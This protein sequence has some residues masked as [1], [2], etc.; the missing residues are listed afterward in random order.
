MSRTLPTSEHFRLQQIAEG[1]YAAIDI[2]RGAAFS[3]A[4]II[5]LGDLTLIF[6]TLMTPQAARD[7][8]AAAEHLTGRPTD[9]CVNSHRHADH[10]SGSQVFA[11]HATIISTD[12]T[13]E[14][15]TM[16]VAPALTQ[17]EESAVAVTE[18]MEANKERLATEKDERW[19][20][21]LPIRI[22]YCQHILESLPTLGLCFP[23]L[24]FDTKLVFHGSARTA[25]LLARSGHMSSDAI[26]VLPTE[27]IAFMGDLAF[28]Q[29]HLSMATSDPVAWTAVLEELE[30]PDI[31]TFVPG[32]GPVGSR[33][34]VAVLKQYIAA[35]RELTTRLVKAGGSAE[36]TAR[37]P[38]P[39]P[40]DAWSRGMDRYPANL[41][42]LDQRLLGG[43]PVI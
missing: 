15:M 19:R 11:D 32:H 5:D 25:E 31:E 17:R 1:A 42:Y 14:Q 24:T 22:A 12:Q 6:D 41:R 2:E 9:F 10:W 3:N 7:L 40:F 29:S 8:R 33:M 38:V 34:D 36:E 13:R 39:A 27:C 30:G 21:W 26:L 43:V 37:Q 23:S 20:A 35:L 18:Q 28:F 16:H 4:G